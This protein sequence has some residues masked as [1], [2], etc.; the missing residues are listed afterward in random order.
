MDCTASQLEIENLS[1]FQK[2]LYFTRNAEEEIFCTFD[3][4]FYRT[5]WY[6]KADIVT[7]AENSALGY[8]FPVAKESFHYL[9]KTT[10]MLR[11]P[12]IKVKEEYQ[13]DYE[14]A[15]CENLGTNLVKVAQFRINNKV[16]QTLTPLNYDVY[17]QYLFDKKGT[18]QRK[19]YL[20]GIGS[21]KELTTFAK[22]LPSYPLVCK[23]PFFYSADNSMAFPLFYCKESNQVD[24]LYNIQN[25]VNSLIRLRKKVGDNQYEYVES[26]EIH[27]YIDSTDFPSPS[28]VQKYAYVCKATK[29]KKEDKINCGEITYHIRNYLNF[30][31]NNYYYYGEIASKKITCTSPV[32]AFFLLAENAYSKDINNHSNYTTNTNNITKGWSPIVNVTMSYTS[33]KHRLDEIPAEYLTIAEAEYFPSASYSRGYIPYAFANNLSILNEADTTVSFAGDGVEFKCLIDNGDIYQYNPIR[34]KTPHKQKHQEENDNPC[35]K[36]NL[37]LLVYQKIVIKYDATLQ[38]YNFKLEE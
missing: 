19:N 3:T 2:E 22:V 33:N 8:I 9:L 35:Y 29:L 32:L 11:T 10:L 24:L 5:T 31:F 15:F 20:R 37:V 14:I 16:Y 28:L 18:G 13:N 36:I 12:C 21:C 23:Q 17:V 26:A 34:R 30:E 38:R 4:T 6:V 7:K 1:I 25:K 27:K